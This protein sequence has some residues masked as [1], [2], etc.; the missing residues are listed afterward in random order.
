M[1]VVGLG[2][3]GVDGWV[4]GWVVLDVEGSSWRGWEWSART[5][6]WELQP[7][8]E[9]EGGRDAQSGGWRLGR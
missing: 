1:L 6:G 4:S 2:G 3:V 7:F 5:Q 9:G 8:P